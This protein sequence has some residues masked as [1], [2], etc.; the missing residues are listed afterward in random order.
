MY[1]LQIRHRSGRGGSQ[2]CSPIFLPTDDQVEGEEEEGWA[3]W[4]DTD[5]HCG[6]RTSRSAESRKK[7]FLT[8]GGFCAKRVIGGREGGRRLK[9][10]RGEGGK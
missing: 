5:R 4:T 3:I 1:N 7:E 8:V 9:L 10:G 2:S 6:V